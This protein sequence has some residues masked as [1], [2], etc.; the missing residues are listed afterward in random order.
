MKK[1]ILLHFALITLV[2][3]AFAQNVGIGIAAPTSKLHV[4]HANINGDGVQITNT[5]AGSTGSTA[6]DGFKIGLGADQNKT[7]AVLNQQELS[8]ILVK[9]NNIERLRLDSLGNLS[10]NKITKTNGTD[11]VAVYAG[12]VTGATA[13]S[14]RNY[15][16]NAYANSRSAIYAENNAPG[17]VSG[18]TTVINYTGYFFNKGASATGANPP[19]R[20]MVIKNGATNGLVDA[21]AFGI[22][23]NGLYVQNDYTGVDMGAWITNNGVGVNGAALQA[24][25]Y[26]DVAGTN[27]FGGAKVSLAGQTPV[28][29]ATGNVY[30]FGVYGAA[31]VGPGNKTGG[32]IGI[33]T[34][35]TGT[36]QGSVNGGSLGYWAA[37][38]TEVSVYGFS[39]AH[40]NGSAS[41]RYN[42]HAGSI[43]NITAEPTSHVGLAMNGAVMG[44]WIQGQVYGT[45]MRGERFSTYIDGAAITNKPI[46][47]LIQVDGAQ[48]RVAT[49]ASVAQTADITARGKGKLVDGRAVVTMDANFSKM[50]TN[51]VTV[52]VTPIGDCNGIHLV[53]IKDGGFEIAE[54]QRGKSDVEFTWIAIGQLKNYT[55]NTISKE[56]LDNSFDT[57]MRSVTHDDNDDVTPTPIWF[58][59]KDVR[60]DAIPAGTIKR[61]APEGMIGSKGAVKQTVLSKD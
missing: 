52:T 32:V 39:K 14:P 35:V 50:V 26:S 17:L 37:N 23:S 42:P 30:A 22:R 34:F 49:Y 54:N 59:G 60:F 38:G 11:L 44:G 19:T 6:T 20:A 15:A 21:S 57:K 25:N 51:D 16:I 27:F 18:G 8:N 55:N 47:Q 10:I 31:G 48:E 56:I 28:S 46:A 3:N 13:T 1:V 2:T 4:E 24:N 7:N 58:D 5:G 29:T 53:S 61:V 33:S 9:T 40:V 45:Y 43:G 36:S 12:D 41:G